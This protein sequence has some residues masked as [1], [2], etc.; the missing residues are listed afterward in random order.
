MGIRF[1]ASDKKRTGVGV[2]GGFV[3]AFYRARSAVL[4]KAG[5]LFC[6]FE[7][8]HETAGLVS[9]TGPDNLFQ[10]RNQSFKN[11]I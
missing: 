2:T 8:I 3:M 10:D 6:F 4:P 9:L 7:G 11:T 1:I 5:F